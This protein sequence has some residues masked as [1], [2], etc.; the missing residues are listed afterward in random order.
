MG[1]PSDNVAGG[2]S[3]TETG[4]CW[5]HGLKLASSTGLFGVRTGP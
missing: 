3:Y 2:Y 1:G 4:V 5:G